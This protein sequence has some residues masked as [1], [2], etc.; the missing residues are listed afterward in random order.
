MSAE[1]D[2]D[3]FFKFVHKRGGDMGTISSHGQGSPALPRRGKT[4]SPLRKNSPVRKSSLKKNQPLRDHRSS[5][6]G[7]SQEVT[8][9]VHR[10][11]LQAMNEM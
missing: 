4:Q 9:T 10:N 7:F 2:A 1:K 3:T 5:R 11:S 6:D 8:P